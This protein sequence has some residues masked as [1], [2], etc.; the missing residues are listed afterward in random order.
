MANKTVVITRSLSQSLEFEKELK[1]EGFETILLSSIEIQNRT[2][3]DNS[4][5]VLDKLQNQ[6][7]DW[8]VFSSANA[9][10]ALAELQ[11][12]YFEELD[13]LLPP[14]ILEPAKVA[15][16]GEKTASVFTDLYRRPINLIPEKFVAESLVDEFDKQDI[17][18][19]RILLI[20]A[21]KTRDIINSELKKRGAIV[22]ELITYD[23]LS[24]EPEKEI[25]EELRSKDPKKLI[26]SFFSPSAV[27]STFSILAK[28]KSLLKES[29]IIS[30][31]PI[32]TK[33][34]EEKGIVNIHQSSDHSQAGLLRLLKSKFE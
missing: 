8:V 26:F 18:E 23:T 9:V 14:V 6:S 1:D 29:Q 3:D 20:L 5:N 13:S 31:G 4:R 11:Q 22:S 32:T 15:V 30:I 16:I 17:V 10:R 25:L 28:D 24:I 33:A 34:L 27:E 21:S 19:Q 7:F 12:A 2:L